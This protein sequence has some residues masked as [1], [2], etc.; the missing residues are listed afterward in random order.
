MNNYSFLSVKVS[1]YH[2]ELQRPR[3]EY[4]LGDQG[5]RRKVKGSCLGCLA[6]AGGR[7][8]PK[9]VMAVLAVLTIDRR[10]ISGGEQNA[11]NDWP[12]RES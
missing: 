8:G 5:V 11:D 3:F 7:E 12:A 6:A 10:K 4:F 1:S 9:R 2:I